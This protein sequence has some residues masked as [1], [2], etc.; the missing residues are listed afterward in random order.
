[1]NKFP[2]CLK[3]SSIIPIFKSGS[4]SDCGSYRPISILPT[5]AKVFEYC[6]YKQ[7]LNFF[8]NNTLLSNYQNG[9]RSQHSTVTTLLFLND[10]ILKSL[11]LGYNALVFFLDLAKAFDIINHD[12]LLVKLKSL[13]NFSCDSIAFI[14]SYLVGRTFQVL[15]D[16]HC[17]SEFTSLYGVP[18]GSTLGPFLFVI[19]INDLFLTKLQTV[20]PSCFADDTALMS[21]INSFQTL[22]DSITDFS[23][24]LCWFRENHLVLNHDK[25]FFVNFFLKKNFLKDTNSLK[26]NDSDFMIVDTLKYLGIYLDSRLTY[27]KQYKCL[28]RKLY[29]FLKMFTKLHMLPVQIKDLMYISNILPVIEYAHIVYFHFNLGCFTKLNKINNRLLKFTTFCND[30]H[31]SINQRLTKTTICYLFKII[32][33]HYPSYLN[34]F[35]FSRPNSRIPFVNNYVHT[36]KAKLSHIYYGTNFVNHLS[37]KHGLN[38]FTEKLSFILNKFDYTFSLLDAIN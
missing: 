9:F 20:T 6:I 30:E 19:Y 21:R 35:S 17:S 10:Y 18:Q 24:V 1:M 34:E 13:Y 28:Y 12:I 31:Y 36:T 32:H 29:Y 15:H 2:Q 8:N 26:I 33:N 23:S 14:Q 38:F 4:I 37:S 16:G 5:I 27:K 7:L 22:D 11:D 25:S 3:K